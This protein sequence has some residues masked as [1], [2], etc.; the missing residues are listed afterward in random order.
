M[1]LF[2]QN[3]IKKQ[4]FWPFDHVP[5]VNSDYMTTDCEHW[6]TH[7]LNINIETRHKW[8]YNEAA[9]TYYIYIFRL[10]LLSRLF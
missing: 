7:L 4:V 6:V 10:T 1:G 9:G 5:V 8:F 2:C 3:N